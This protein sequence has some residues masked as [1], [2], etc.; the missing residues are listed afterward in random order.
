MTSAALIAEALAGRKIAARGGNYL[1]PCPAHEDDSPSLSLKDGDSGIVVHC[2]AGCNARDVF[3][4]IRRRDGRLP[5]S[6]Q[7][8]A[9]PPA[10]NSAEYERHQ[11]DKAAWLWSRRRPIG[12]S[13]AERY[14][15]QARGYPAALPL[16]PSLAFLPPLKREHHP[17]L[18]AAFALVDEPEPGKLGSPRHVDS[19]QLVLLKPDGSAKADVELPKLTIGR[20]RARPIVLAPPNDLLGLAITEGIEDGLTAHAA[21]GLGAWASASAGFMPALADAVPGYIEAVTIFA[22]ADKAGQEGARKL[23]AALRAQRIETSLEGLS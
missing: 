14:L 5:E 9:P 8:P 20:P 6:G 10:K 4:A 18:I 3:A 15:R 12:G 7:A 22:H 13:I 21:T 16:P 2:F 19:V 17:A 1:V 23:A 11:H